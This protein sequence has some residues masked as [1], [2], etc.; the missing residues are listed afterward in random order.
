MLDEYKEGIFRS[1]YRSF[2]QNCKRLRRLAKTQSRSAS[3]PRSSFFQRDS[4]DQHKNKV[5]R[6]IIKLSEFKP[7]NHETDVVSS[8]DG[9][10]WVRLSVFGEF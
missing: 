4:I 6:L 7:Q 3:M 1:L 5:N 2:A 8:E 9:S 10:E